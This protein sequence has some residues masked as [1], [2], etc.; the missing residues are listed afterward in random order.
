MSATAASVAPTHDTSD[1]P[2]A[3]TILG[4]SPGHLRNL[5]SQGEGPAFYRVGR[6]VIYKRAD[7]DA[8]LASCRVEP[9][10]R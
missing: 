5:R 7:L 4:I 9:G 2:G 1:T 3:A 8:F 10:A 6:R